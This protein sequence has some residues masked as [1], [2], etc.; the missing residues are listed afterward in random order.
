LAAYSQH[1]ML[2]FRRDLR[3]S[4]GGGCSKLL[5]IEQPFLSS[6]LSASSPSFAKMRT[7]LEEDAEVKHGYSCGCGRS[8]GVPG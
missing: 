1:H 5:E 7:R 4:E 2:S 8:R 3:Y 6:P